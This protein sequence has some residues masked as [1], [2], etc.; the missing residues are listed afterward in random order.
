MLVG[1]QVEVTPSA[2]LEVHWT[3]FKTN[4]PVVL[5]HNAFYAIKNRANERTM[6]PRVANGL[7]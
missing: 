3:H 7:V 2:I 4:R 1:T 5:L 6:P